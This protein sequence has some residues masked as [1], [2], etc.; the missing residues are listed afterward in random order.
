MINRPQGLAPIVGEW[1]EI[2]GESKSQAGRPRKRS[3]EM[4]EQICS[5]CVFQN[6][7]N[8]CD[9]PGDD[10]GSGRCDEYNWCKG[11]VPRLN[12]DKALTSILDAA[13]A[14]YEGWTA[15]DGGLTMAA[16]DGLATVHTIRRKAAHQSF[17]DF[18]AWWDKWAG[19][20]SDTS[21]GTEQDLL[22]SIQGW[23]EK[24]RIRIVRDALNKCDSPEV[25]DAVAQVL[26]LK[27]SLPGTVLYCDVSGDFFHATWIGPTSWGQ[28]VPAKNKEAIG[29]LVWSMTFLSTSTE[30]EEYLSE[31][32]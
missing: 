20:F 5:T 28:K 14:E 25:I 22:S 16:S 29:H 3:K 18:R 8:G 9:R 27:N 6:L 1:E 2:T 12:T 4:V 23:I 21:T 13:A 15:K 11:W 26:G 19:D 17:H 32:E 24:K 30:V 10:P 31:S 7:R